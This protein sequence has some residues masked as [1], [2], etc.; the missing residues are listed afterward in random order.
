[1]NTT[2]L[3]PGRAPRLARNPRTLFAALTP[4]T[5]GAIAALL[6]AVTLALGAAVAQAEDAT[7][8]DAAVVVNINT[9]DAQALAEKLSGVGVTRAEE[10]VRYREH[11]GPFSTLDE[12]LDVKGI[13][14]ATLEANRQ[15]IT[16]E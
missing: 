14:Q 3:V 11:Y 1:M 7:G 4:R 16:L 15:R 2:Q 12:L 6:L 13:G 10:I 8:A 5:V 9:E